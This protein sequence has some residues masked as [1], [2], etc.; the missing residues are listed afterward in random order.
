MTGIKTIT[1]TPAK[2]GVIVAMWVLGLVL[3]A[4]FAWATQWRTT[5]G[6]PTAGIPTAGSTSPAVPATAAPALAA[7]TTGVQRDTTSA[8]ASLQAGHRSDA[9]AA[10]D[11]ARRL[12]QVGQENSSGPLKTQYVTALDA[13]ESARQ[14]LWN[15]NPGD[16]RGDLTAAGQA[17]ASAVTATQTA[18]DP[19]APPEAV[20]DQYDGAQLL[21]ADGRVIGKVDSI[22]NPADPAVRLHL[23]NGSGV[24]GFIDLGGHTTTVPLDQVL[25][26]RRQILG[27]VYAVLTSSAAG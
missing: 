14:A 4:L 2:V 3:L 8:L 9:T 21:A 7:L 12:A 19:E 22:D 15:G 23:G 17:L 25:W 26:G 10:L 16:A 13:I 11:A 24:L 18:T 5:A 1:A 27:N 6:I 20:W